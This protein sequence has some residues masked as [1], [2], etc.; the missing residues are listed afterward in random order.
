MIELSVTGLLG[1]V[2]LAIVIWAIIR[3][4]ESTAGPLSKFL[5]ILILLFFPCLGL[6]DLVVAGAQSTLRL[7]PWGMNPNCV[8]PQLRSP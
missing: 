6:I 4:A 8:T 2:W 3:T 1:I 7:P 5:W